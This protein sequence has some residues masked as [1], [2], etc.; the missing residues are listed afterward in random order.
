M[1]LA[2]S[3]V[4]DGK[5]EQGQAFLRKRYLIRDI[6]KVKERVLGTTGKRTFPSWCV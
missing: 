2:R 6:S 1:I 5:I 3:G 4:M